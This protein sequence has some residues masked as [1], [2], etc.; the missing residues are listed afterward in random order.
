[1]TDP[2]FNT[3]EPTFHGYSLPEILTHWHATL[4]TIDNQG[5]YTFMF[6]NMPTAMMFVLAMGS[7]GKN[8]D[9][10]VFTHPEHIGPSVDEPVQLTVYHDGAGPE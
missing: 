10:V 1:M 7:V 6:P 3:G 2:T 9:R 4:E 8:R 5:R